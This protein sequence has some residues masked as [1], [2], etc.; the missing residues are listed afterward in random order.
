MQVDM[1]S[2]ELISGLLELNAMWKPNLS[3]AGS[4]MLILALLKRH[5]IMEPA[6]FYQSM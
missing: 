2:M 6:R 4:D 1:H 3:G 5:V